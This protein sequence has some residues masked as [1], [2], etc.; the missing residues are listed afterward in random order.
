MPVLVDEESAEVLSISLL[1]RECALSLAELAVFEMNG[2]FLNAVQ[3]TLNHQLQTNLVS[4]RIQIAS[5]FKGFAGKREKTR[6]RIL[7]RGEG[8]GA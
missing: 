7:Y 6:H 5:G 4:N 3:A 2:N 1:F 8:T